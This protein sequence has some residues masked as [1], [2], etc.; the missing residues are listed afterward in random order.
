MRNKGQ[1]LAAWNWQAYD[2]A[3]GFIPNE[4]EKGREDFDLAEEIEK[5]DL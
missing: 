3:E 4:D 5:A 1:D 2:R